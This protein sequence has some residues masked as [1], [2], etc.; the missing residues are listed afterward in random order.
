VADPSATWFNPAGLSRQTSAQISGSAGL[1]QRTSVSPQAL[2]NEGGSVQHLPNFVGFT[3]NVRDGLTAGFALLTTNS[4]AQ[5]TD[6]QLIT[7][8]PSGQERFAY[9][10]DSAFA[11]RIAALGVGGQEDVGR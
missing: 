8:V 7:S 4:W 3:F 9:S 11:R 5:E 6:S 1:Y 2:P 10:A